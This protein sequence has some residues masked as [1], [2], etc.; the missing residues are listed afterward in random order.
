M[1]STMKLLLAST[2]AAFMLMSAAVEAQPAGGG[3]MG[4]GPG[5]G[6]GGMGR[7]GGMGPGAQW[8][9]NRN[10]TPGYALMTPEERTAH[11]NEMRS[12]KTYAECRTYVDEFRQKMTERAKEQ[13]K[14]APMMRRDPCVYWQ[15]K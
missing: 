12:K 11:F 3:G 2:A 13:G 14:P 5:Y 4:M 1:K 8:R 6:Q 10:N 7:G 15:Q 9:M